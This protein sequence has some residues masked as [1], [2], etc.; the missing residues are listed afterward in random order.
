MR[1]QRDCEKSERNVTGSQ[2]HQ[3][4]RLHAVELWWIQNE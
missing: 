4:A 3:T 1:L 2:A